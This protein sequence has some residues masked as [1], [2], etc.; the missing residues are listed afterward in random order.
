ML[1]ELNEKNLKEVK[2]PQFRQYAEIYTNINIQFLEKVRENGLDFCGPTENQQK[3]IRGKI[4]AKGAIF[5]N[6]DKSIYTNWISPACEACKK[7]EDTSTFYLSLK[8]HRHCYYCF[9]PNQEDYAY[10]TVN[11]RDC[12]SELNNIAKTGQ[13][14]NH[15]ALTGGEPLLHK[16]DTMEFLTYAKEKFPRTYTRLY[17]SGD[18]VDQET[19][20]DLRDVKLDEIRFSIKLEDDAEL[21]RKVMKNITLAKESIPNV[22]VEMP[23][24]PGTL[25]EMKELLQELNQIGIAGI[26]L[27]EFC[28]PYHN[29]QEF[30][31]RAFQIKNPPYKVLYDYWY[32]GGLPIAGSEEDCLALVEYVLD[33]KL[34]IGVHYCSLE[35]KHTGQVFQQNKKE[36]RS[37]L[38]Y[39]SNKDFFLKTAKVFGEDIPEVLKLFRKNKVMDYRMNEEYQS[40]EFHVR[41]VKL[42]KKLPIEV[43]I[44]SNI[45]ELREDGKYLRELKIELVYPESFAFHMV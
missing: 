22:M 37:R 17:T 23:V 31:Q 28:F 32:A 18:L 19:L 33:E 34:Q 11:R 7:G 14:L 30:Q 36:N 24:I 13:K 38:L 45:M 29:V 12:I 15:I 2:N 39:F 41:E 44:S 40:L 27:L 3:E 9:N 35:N 21:R 42:L 5:R 16:K 6:D 4:E 25:Q 20:G 43:G 1:L 10:S 26:N 8:C